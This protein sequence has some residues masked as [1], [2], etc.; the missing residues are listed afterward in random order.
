MGQTNSTFNEVIGDLNNNT[1]RKFI[2]KWHNGIED[3]ELRI[4]MIHAL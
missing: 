1:E 3:R 2:G 4:T